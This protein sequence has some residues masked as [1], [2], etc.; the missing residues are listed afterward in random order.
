M[1]RERSVLPSIPPIAFST[2]SSVI[3]IFS[4]ARSVAVNER[5]SIRR[6][7]KVCSRRAPMFSTSRLIWVARWASRFL[8]PSVMSSWLGLGF[9]FGLRLGLGLGSVRDV[10][11][12]RGWGEGER[13]A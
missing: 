6:S 9:G 5:S 13:E 12:Q 2:S 7:T 8:A 4:P 10:E 1:K 3:V 11:L